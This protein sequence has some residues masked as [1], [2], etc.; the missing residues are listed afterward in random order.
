MQLTLQGMIVQK[1]WNEL[2]NHFDNVVLDEYITMPNHVHGIIIITDTSR[3]G[4][5][6]S[7]LPGKPITLGKMVAYYKYQSTKQINTMMNN[8][9]AKIWQRNYYDH[10]IRNDKEYSHPE[11]VEG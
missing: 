2:P 4:E 6:T 3:R 5:V 9:G 8:I 1:C 7:P 11:L 10:I